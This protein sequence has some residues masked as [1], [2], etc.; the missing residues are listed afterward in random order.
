MVKP[1]RNLFQSKT[2]WANVIAA[3]AFCSAKWL[4]YPMSVET[5][6]GML[7]AVNTI[8]RLVTDGKVTVA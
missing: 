3:V 7:L 5:Q 8:M 2:F 1:I 6:A 4:D